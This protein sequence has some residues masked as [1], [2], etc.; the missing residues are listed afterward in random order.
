MNA[1]TRIALDFYQWDILLKVVAYT[2]INNIT[3]LLSPENRLFLEQNKHLKRAINHVIGNKVDLQYNNRIDRY[4]FLH[5]YLRTPNCIDKSILKFLPSEQEFLNLYDYCVN[6]NVSAILN[7]SYYMWTSN[8]LVCFTDLVAKLKTGPIQF[9]IELEFDPGFQYHFNGLRFLHSLESIGNKINALVI[10]QC[11]ES[12]ALDMK[13]YPNM[14]SL[15]LYFCPFASIDNL[16]HSKLKSLVFEFNGAEHAKHLLDGLPPTLKIFQANVHTVFLILERLNAGEL[17]LPQLE[18]VIYWNERR[19]QLSVPIEFLKRAISASTKHLEFKSYI[20]TPGISRE[21]TS[22]LESASAEGLTLESLS[23]NFGLNA[24]LSIYPMTSLTIT[25]MNQPDILF[26]LQ[27]PPTLKRLDLSNNS[28][29]DLSPITMLLPPGLE[30]LSFEHNPISWSTYLPNFAKFANLKYLRLMN[31][32]IGKH[33]Q[34]FQFPDSLEILSLE[35][36]QI[37]SIDQVKFP[38]SLVNLGI[39][40][41]KI[42][43]VYKPKFPPTIKT[44]H[45]TENNISKVDLATNH[46]GQPLQIKTLYLDYNKITS[47]SNVKLPSNLIIL[48][49]DN[50]CIHTLSDIEFGKTIE[51]LSFS[52]C[53]IREMRNIIFESESKLKYLCL[54]DNQLKTIG[55]EPPQ[56]VININLSLNKIAKIPHQLANLHNLKYLNLAQNRLRTATFSFHTT[57]LS[58]L[59]LS[60]NSIHKIQ[61]SFPRNTNTNLRS[62][63]LCTNELSQFS[64]KSIGHDQSRGTI[65]G[66]LFEIDLSVNPITKE[67][68]DALIKEIPSSVH[69]LWYFREAKL[70]SAL[71][72]ELK[73]IHAGLS[74]ATISQAR[75]FHLDTGS[76]AVCFEISNPTTIEITKTLGTEPLPLAL[77]EYSH[78]NS[79][80]GLP[81]F[82]FLTTDAK[83]D[84][85]FEFGKF[86]FVVEDPSHAFNEILEESLKFDVTPSVWCLYTPKIS[87]Y[88]YKVSIDEPGYYE[89]YDDIW[90]LVVNASVSLFFAR[91]FNIG[92]NP[93]ILFKAQVHLQLIKVV[94]FSLTTLLV[95]FNLDIAKYAN[96][97][98]ASLD[99]VFTVL[100]LSGYG[101]TY[102]SQQGRSIKKIAFITLLCV[103]P[104]FGIRYFDLKTNIQYILINNQHYNVVQGV[105][106]PEIYDGLDRVARLM[107]KGTV[108]SL[109]GPVTFL[110]ATSKIVKI[111]AYIYTMRKTLKQISAGNPTT[112]PYYIWSIVIWLFLWSLVSAGMAPDMFYNYTKV[113]NYAKVLNEFI[114]SF[115]RRR[116]ITFMWDESHW[117]V[118]WLIW[119]SCKGLMVERKVNIKEQVD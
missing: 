19:K 107:W 114:I 79:L 66:K 46:I 23:L 110:F 16:T 50:C 32:H 104:A 47:M 59:D 45:F 77:F 84:E 5:M 92:S 97:I 38:K 40:S 20:Y 119:Y 2:G 31:T 87:V 56:S 13:S 54:S 99:D 1:G 18:A 3:Q 83:L 103:I 64:I 95:F 88:E 35:V 8:D 98:S 108:N 15:N 29:E 76:N 73:L 80:Q 22:L 48:N 71:G 111:S 53:E 52:G 34:R 106:G 86:T 6:E 118:F 28:I 96:F 72:H 4:S 24:P 63:N 51:E 117:I 91:L 44:I 43:V 112:R 85:Y 12:F 105:L 93:P 36:N 39:G 65:H 49:F 14:E 26:E 58:V 67:D 27:Y 33:F 101:L 57:T 60:F 68:M 61:L 55:F 94:V 9:N 70:D 41:N 37:E 102:D 69:C 109:S 62:V 30:F 116:F 75:Q 7:I 113:T 78:R 11:A 82:D 10:D 115:K 90:W 100:F 89:K 42:K 74:L 25:K 81:N 17:R 21:V